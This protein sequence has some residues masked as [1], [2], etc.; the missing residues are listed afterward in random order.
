MVSVVRW[1][2]CMVYSWF[3]S[4]M[5]M[6]VCVHRPLWRGLVSTSC[7][8]GSMPSSRN[9]LS[10]LRLAGPNAT[11]STSRT[12]VVRAIQSTSGLTLLP[13]SAG[14]FLTSS[15]HLSQWLKCDHVIVVIINIISCSSIII[16]TALMADVP[17]TNYLLI[18]WLNA[19]HARSVARGGNQGG[20][21][22][23]RRLSGFF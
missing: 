21:A 19:V 20:M 13:W 2:R 1:C 14:R 7:W 3:W 16:N 8:R 18:H 15:S 12:C 4:M 11:S 17:L 22:P 23:N 10:T 6:C 9:V 5:E